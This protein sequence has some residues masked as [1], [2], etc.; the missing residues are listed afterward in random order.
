MIFPKIV[1][2]AGARPGPTIAIFAGVHGNELA[3]VLALQE[4]I[5]TLEVTK[6]K[7]FIAFANPPAIEAGVRMV[8]KNLNRCFFKENQGTTSEDTRARELMRVLD[9]CDALLD[10]HMFYDDKGSPFVICE[11]PAIDIALKFDVDIISTNWTKTEPGA[12]DGYMHSNGKIGLCVECGPISQWMMYKEFAKTTIYQFLKHFDMTD[13]PVEYSARPKRVI[14]AKKIVYKKSKHFILS[15]RLHNF[16][17]LQA[18]QIIATEGKK[19]Y[20]A[21]PGE[22]IIFP[23]YNARIGEEAYIIGTELE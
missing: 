22:Y 9:K 3:G 16:D 23:H 18:G 2:I 13:Q 5:P 6:G 21:K 20:I 10:L 4:L 17:A 11:D 19:K 1:M 8:G 7:V 14:K 15:A 12:S